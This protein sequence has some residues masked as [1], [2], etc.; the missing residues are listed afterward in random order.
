MQIDKCM[1]QLQENWRPNQWLLRIGIR[2]SASW[3]A[4]NFDNLFPSVDWPQPPLPPP[5]RCI[6]FLF[7]F[8][9]LCLCLSIQRSSIEK[10]CWG[11][12][13]PIGRKI[14][15]I[16]DCTSFAQ[17]KGDSVSTTSGFTQRRAFSEQLGPGMGRPERSGRC[18]VLW[19]SLWSL[20][21]DLWGLGD[22]KI[23]LVMASLA[24]FV[25]G[26][27][28]SYSLSVRSI[29]SSRKLSLKPK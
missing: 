12:L 23:W 7:F 20:W 26:A 19:W 4:S 3:T 27:S 8:P 2:K 25:Q 1:N 29:N 11:N 9:F 14:R 5:L 24:E 15:E 6:P 28:E 10:H 17:D 21:A 22:L 18:G 13:L 16:Q